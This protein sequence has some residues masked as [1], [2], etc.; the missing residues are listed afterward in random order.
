MKNQ[1]YPVKYIRPI[2]L[3]DGTLVQLRPIHI[4]D[5]FQA[6]VFKDTLSH[7]SLNSRFF[8]N[9]PK[10]TEANIKKYVDIDYNSEMAIVA[11]VVNHF[12]KEIIGIGRIAKHSEFENASEFGIIISDAW[13]ENNLGN[14]LTSY[15]IYIAKD[16][17]Y[18]YLY[19]YTY[20]NNKRMIKILKKLDFQIAN[21]DYQTIIAKLILK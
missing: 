13:Q 4:V 6:S 19:A 21:D 7:E 20:R 5:G 17:G 11:E 15:L 1:D 2:Q 10:I 16:M 18:D 8:G 12:K 14:I 3:N 9:S